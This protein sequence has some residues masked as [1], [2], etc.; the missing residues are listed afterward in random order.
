MDDS[1]IIKMLHDRNEQALSAIRAEYGA[2]CLALCQR[3]LGSSAD[4]EEC[5]NDVLMEVW[6]SVPPQQPK[7]LRAYLVAAARRR[8]V[9]RLRAD[10]AAK[11]GGKQY[12][13]A[14]D[15]LSDVLAAPERV[16]ETADAHALSAAVQQF[17]RE[18]SP[19]TRQMF[20][21]RYYLAM[22]LQEIAQMRGMTSGAVKAQLR[23]TR[24]RLREYLQ[25]EGFL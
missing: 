22:P 3:L 24:T 2:L 11:R 6:Q 16:E 10:T 9:D 8:A 23:R 5:L 1:M 13:L 15:E 18:C 21:Q 25:R 14:L 19:G 17:L 20:M 4:A 12:Q 7:N